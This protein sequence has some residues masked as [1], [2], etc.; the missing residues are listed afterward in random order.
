M[1]CAS[2]AA[3]AYAQERSI[4]PSNSFGKLDTLEKAESGGPREPSAPLHQGTALEQ[5]GAVMIS[6]F[7]QPAVR[8]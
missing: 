6:K 1:A 5:G 2:V 4:A 7:V 3:P 8:S